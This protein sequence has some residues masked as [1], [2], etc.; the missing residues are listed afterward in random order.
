MRY[1]MKEV[2]LSEDH[3]QWPNETVFKLMDTEMSRI[4]LGCYTSKGLAEAIMDRKNHCEESQHI[5]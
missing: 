5:H 2:T 4:S 1:T 3:P